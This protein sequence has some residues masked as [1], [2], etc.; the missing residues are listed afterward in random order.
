MRRERFMASDIAGSSVAGAAP[1][2][3]D[4][5]TGGADGVCAEAAPAVTTNSS[6]AAVRA[7]PGSQW[8]AFADACASII[9]VNNRDPV[10]GK[11][12]TGQRTVLVQSSITSTPQ[13]N[14]GAYPKVIRESSQYAN[15]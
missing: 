10:L 13:S 2:G 4:A 12:E 3:A 7:Q 8:L 14:H 5:S 11:F 15:Y 9:G 1:G 6:S